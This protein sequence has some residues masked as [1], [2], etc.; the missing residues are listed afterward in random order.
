MKLITIENE[1]NLK[2]DSESNAVVNTDSHGYKAYKKRLEIQAI[3]SNK[4]KDQQEQINNLLK[5]LSNIKDLIRV[6]NKDSKCQ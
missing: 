1:S 5:E 4:I 6:I 2:R 3:N